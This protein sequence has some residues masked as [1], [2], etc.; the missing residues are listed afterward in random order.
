MTCLVLAAVLLAACDGPE[1]REA[2]HFQRGQAFFESGNYS[3]ARLEF[4]NVL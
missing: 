4:R 1:Q 3:K 2:A